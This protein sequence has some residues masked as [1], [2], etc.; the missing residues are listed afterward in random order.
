M[1]QCLCVGGAEPFLATNHFKSSTYILNILKLL[2]N[3][4]ISDAYN[5]RRDVV[6]DEMEKAVVMRMETNR[7][8][9]IVNSCGFFWWGQTGGGRGEF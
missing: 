2:C 4:G 7:K 6:N 8:R 3:F 5:G 1:D 9:L